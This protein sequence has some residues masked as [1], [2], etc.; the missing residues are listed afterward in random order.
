MTVAPIEVLDP[1][2]AK[3]N[4][5]LKYAALVM[6][7]AF[8]L[9][10]VLFVVATIARSKRRAASKNA[11]DHMELGAKRDY[12]E[13]ARRERSKDLN[14]S[15]EE[16][17][18]AKKAV[19]SSRPSDEVLKEELEAEKAQSDAEPV[20]QQANENGGYRLTREAPAAPAEAKA[21][22]PAPRKRNRRSDRK[23]ANEDE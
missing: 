8:A 2:T 15:A 23:K 7:S 14:D 10:F 18:D 17:F 22:E 1:V 4:E 5:V 16:T 11:Y 9:V 3:T 6:G 12:R 13:P 19:E 21:E 20:A